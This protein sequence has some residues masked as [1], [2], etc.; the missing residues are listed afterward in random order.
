M[1][2]IVLVAIFLCIFT[3]TGV[4]AQEETVLSSA[5][6]TPDNFFYFLDV[7]REKISLFFTFSSEGKIKKAI[8]Y[9]E[10]KLAETSALVD[11]G[12]YEL[13][14]KATGLYEDYIALS[15]RQT[16]EIVKE[17]QNIEDVSTR[18]A[19]ATSKH[20]TVLEELL[21]KV[22]EQAKDAIEK[23]ITV[24]MNGHNRALS[25]LAKENPK[26]AI[27]INLE[28][29][30]G[31]LERAKKM[32]EKGNAE[33]A[34]EA[35]ENFEILNKLGQEISQIAKGVGK[36]TTTVEQLVGGATSYHLEV[37]SEVYKKVPDSAK[38]SIEEAISNSIKGHQE[39]VDSLK[40]KNAIDEVP[41]EAPIPE[42][43]PEEIKN[44]ALKMQEVV[45]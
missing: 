32:A 25:A 28:T 27:E 2:K 19:E 37:L 40:K 29:I 14:P 41:E 34:E 5:G 13:L 3:I 20:L 21:D 35:V 1:K 33:Q 8:T 36:D 31:R 16:D 39:I 12:E 10:E 11:K 45:P 9:G 30:K 7:W 42:E 4:F 22:P 18:V 26:K 15:N 17:G 44:R 43:L 23:A 38:P 24:S 6:M